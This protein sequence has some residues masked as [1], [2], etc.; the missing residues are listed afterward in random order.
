MPASHEWSASSDQ[1]RNESCSS[2]KVDAAKVSERV[3]AHV[4]KD[5]RFDDLRCIGVVDS[6]SAVVEDAGSKTVQ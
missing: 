6:D 3:E 1:D 4:F 5:E 2:I